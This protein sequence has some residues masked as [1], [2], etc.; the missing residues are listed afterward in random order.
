MVGAGVRAVGPQRQLR[1]IAP[2]M[3]AGIKKILMIGGQP[4]EHEELLGAQIA[5]ERRLDDRQSGG[6]VYRNHGL[7]SGTGFQPVSEP[8]Q[9]LT[10]FL[11]SAPPDTGWESVPQSIKRT[12]QVPFAQ[13]F[14]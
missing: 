1:M 4:I 2:T 3:P 13:A 7:C 10:H 9:K 6:F 5:A 8:F 12:S 14:A 11:L